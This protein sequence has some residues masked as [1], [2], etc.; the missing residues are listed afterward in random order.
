MMTEPRKTREEA[1]IFESLQELCRSNGFI[2]TIAYFCFKANAVSYDPESGIDVDSFA[3]QYSDERLLRT[4]INL[5]LGLL[6]RS[7]IDVKMIDG[8]Q[9]QANIDKTESL[10]QELHDSILP[11]FAD[12]V[13]QE[14]NPDPEKLKEIIESSGML[15]EAVFYGGESA[16]HF[17]YRDLASKRYKRDSDYFE[18]KMGFSTESVVS[19]IK[20]LNSL[21]DQQLNET[22]DSFSKAPPDE[23]NFLN[24]FRFQ[25]QDICNETELQRSVVEAVIAA[26][27]I[28]VPESNHTFNQ[29][30]DFNIVNARPILKLND[31]EILL[32]QHYSL[33]ESFYESPFFWMKD[34]K[35]Y[36]NIA[37][38]NRGQF[39]EDFSEERLTRVFGE[40]N[41]FSNVEIFSKGGD[42]V[43]E[44][45][46]LVLFANRALIV[47]AKSKTLTIAARQGLKDKIEEDF[48]K[49]V[50][51]AYEQGYSCAELILQPDNYSL[52]T[53]TG[54]T[55][56]PRFKLDDVYI[57]CVVSDHY[58][59]LFHQSRQFL[60]YNVTENINA[61]YVADVFL[62][63]TLTEF[64]DSPIR[65]LSFI[66]RRSQY[67]GSLNASM[68]LSVLGYH[69]SNNLW[70]EEENEFF[71]FDDSVAVEL[72]VAMTVRRTGIKGN[73][74]PK[75]I[76]TKFENTYVGNLLVEIEDYEH[77]EVIDFGF[78]LLRLSSESLEQINECIERCIQ[79]YSAD[80]KTHDFSMPLHNGT[81]FTFH[82]T[83]RERS[84]ARNKLASHCGL[85]KYI[86]R[87]DLWYGICLNPVTAKLRFG[88]SVV[89]QW[90]KDD[91]MEQAAKEHDK[92]LRQRP[93]ILYRR[94]KKKVGRNAPC[95]CGSGKKYKKCCL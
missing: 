57:M 85:R 56:T 75:G 28:N 20:A 67:E 64:L 34:D 7:G 72:D 44:I 78:E 71:H 24:A 93:G 40:E 17:Q 48:Q 36:R 38:E 80:G 46:T 86:G 9:M 6:V 47:Q 90:E 77:A 3:N 74:T 30:D 14:G 62:L 13:D 55:I 89:G 35:E 51:S 11:S 84:D 31:N 61:P 54:I 66:N 83:D 50:Q 42:V 53:R 69:L 15:R 22:L 76:L 25:I 27:A 52:K 95:P 2:H 82:L 87:S 18:S 73:E 16:Y 37:S 65:F 23:W 4:E 5:L 45:D 60:N 63:D 70:L 79:L 81:G 68:E 43:G 29:V 94:A 91:G 33:V 1:E 12:A 8:H 88:L 26:F 41:V 10:L 49:A 58:P 19:V 21:F 92:T 59:A 32:F 39:T